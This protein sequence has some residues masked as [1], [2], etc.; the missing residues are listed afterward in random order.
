M[1]K[2]PGLGSRIDIVLTLI[3]IGFFFGDHDMITQN[4]QQAEEYVCCMVNYDPSLTV[5][6]YRLVEKGG[7]WDRRNRLKVYRGLHLLSIRQFKRGGEL[8]FDVLS[9]FIATE[10]IS[11][12]DLVARSSSP[13][14][15]PSTD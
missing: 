10:L 5:C 8:L 2:T 15:L 1:E 4:L 9:S 11:Y 3:R 6:A 14:F 7:D 13:M 12:N